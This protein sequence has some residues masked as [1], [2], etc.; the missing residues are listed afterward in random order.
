M[1]EIVQNRRQTAG[2]KTKDGK[3]FIHWFV[4]SFIPTVICLLGATHCLGAGATLADYTDEAPA[5]ITPTFI[6]EAE[7]RLDRQEK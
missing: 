5:S 6:G 2:K 4:H 1:H 3:P 7:N